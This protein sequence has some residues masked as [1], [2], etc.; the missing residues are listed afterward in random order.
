MSWM[1]GVRV[2]AEAGNFSLHHRRVQTG[3][4]A[5]PASYPMGK[6]GV[7]SLGVKRPERELTTHL[8]LVPRSRMRGA[9]PPL[10]QYAFMAWCSVGKKHRDKLTFYLGS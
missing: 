7:L 1:I 4:G 6:T 10:S 9:L 5:H 8:D 3:S 2:P